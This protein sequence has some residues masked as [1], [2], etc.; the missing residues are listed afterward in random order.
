MEQSLLDS[1]KYRIHSVS[2]DSRFADQYNKGTGDFS[3]RMQSTFRNIQRIALSS[4]EIPLVE[5]LFSTTHGNLNFTIKYGAT[6][7]VVKTIAAG[8]YTDTQLVSELESVLQTT[9][10]PAF[11]CSLSPTTGLLTVTHPTTSFELTLTSTDATIADRPTHW[12]LGYYLGFRTKG[13]LSSTGPAPYT[14]TANTVILVQPTPYY[15]LQL[16]CPD[17]VQNITHC[18]TG[19]TSIGAFAKLVLHNNVY[20]IQFNSNADFMRKEFT[21]LAPVNVSQLRVNLVDP[22]GS[23]VDMRSMDWSFMVE[24]YEVVN[25]RT[26][27]HMGLTYDR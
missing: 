14:L 27:A 10:N 22:Y 4:A 2:V 1:S 11:T 23:T 13:T 3:I 24:L 17:E 8:N 15:L 7:P 19:R 12:G 9:V 6:P 21:F 25:S 16:W 20:A 18:T 5:Q 26:Y